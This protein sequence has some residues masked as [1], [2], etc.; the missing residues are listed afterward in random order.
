MQSHLDLPAEEAVS[1]RVNDML[2]AKTAFCDLAFLIQK[3]I[4]ASTLAEA[5]QTVVHHVRKMMNVDV[6]EIYITDYEVSRHVLLATEGLPP[7]LVGNVNFSFGEGL[8]GRVAEQASPFN[9]DNA[10]SHP[11]YVFHLKTGEGSY[12][13]FLGVPLIHQRRVLG[14]L[15]VRQRERRRFHESNVALLVTLA[16]QLAS[17]VAYAQVTAE[18]VG[19]PHAS[20]KDMAYLE[21]QP[22]APGV[23]LGEGL[24]VF[25][26]M[27]L[28]SVPDRAPEDVKKEE[29]AF[30]AA[31]DR[32]VQELSV[33]GASL[34]S[35]IASQCRALFEAYTLL[36]NSSEMVDATVQRIRE[37]NWAPGALRQVIEDHCSHFDKVEDPYLRERSNDLLALGQRLLDQLV[38]ERRVRP[39]YPQQTILVGEQISAIDLAEVPEGRLAGVVSCQGSTLSHVA[40]LAHARGVPAVMGIGEVS[41]QRLDGRELVLDGYLGRVYIEPKGKVRQEFIRVKREEQELAEALSLYRNRPAETLDGLRVPLGVN[42]SSAAEAEL[43]KGVAA[44]S[45]GLFRT[46]LP[47]MLHNRFPSEEEQCSLYRQVLETFAPRMVTIRT[48]DAGGD[49]VLPYLPVRESNPFLGWR[50]MRMTLDRPEIFL[51]QLR[52]ILRAAIGL[53]NVQ[54]LFPMI[55]GVAELEEA[56]KLFEL[57]YQQ[58]CQEGVAVVRPRIGVMIE[59]PSAVYQAKEIAQQVD[60]LSVGTNDLTQYLLAVDRTNPRVAKLLEPLHPA[61]LRALMDVVEAARSVGK[62]V[63]VCGELASDPA[64]VLLLLAMGFDGLSVSVGALPRIRCAVCGFTRERMHALLKTV[65]QCDR[66]DSV[67]KVLHQA[68]EEA[69]LAGLVRAG[70]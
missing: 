48:L 6:C 54:L 24:V 27:A 46:E 1:S 69:G 26:G 49:K 62:P 70:K 34:E 17:A 12:H 9:L 39:R 35:V 47:F 61:V 21:G 29:A 52:A 55:S 58:L 50:G 5:L 60:F 38:T 56:Q 15:V 8:I 31:V 4:S 67:R 19:K 20:H 2:D 10:T 41:L 33:L 51:G 37:G 25:E 45:I 44:D 53:E 57:A 23:V 42:V 40:I 65:L 3:V 13:G 66:A 7:E 59:V 16:A 36:L 28:G 14:V 68:L 18:S 63:S 30:R 43:A 11:D 32:T 22:G 64:A